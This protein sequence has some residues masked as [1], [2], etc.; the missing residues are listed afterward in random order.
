[1]T[2]QDRAKMLVYFSKRFKRL[3]FVYGA[4]GLVLWFVGFYWWA[5]PAFIVAV[6]LFLKPKLDLESVAKG[7]PMA[8]YLLDSNYLCSHLWIY[9]LTVVGGLYVPFRAS[10]ARKMFLWS[11][12]HL[13]TSP[14]TSIFELGEDIRLLSKI[15]L[16]EKEA[17]DFALYYV[18][19]LA[20][21]D[22]WY[23]LGSDEELQKF[24]LLNQTIVKYCFDEIE[25]KL[26]K[27]HAKGFEEI[28]S[29]AAEWFPGLKQE[30]VEQFLSE[31]TGNWVNL[32]LPSGKAVMERNAFET[33]VDAINKT[34]H[35][36]GRCTFQ[37][38][39][40]ELQSR[41]S[42][43]ERDAQAFIGQCDG[44]FR[45]LP[46]ADG[47]YYVSDRL[48]NQI[49]I[50]PAC[51]I[52]RVL[53]KDEIANGYSPYC[54]SY[55]EE[56]DQMEMRQA[57]ALRKEQ[58]GKAGISLGAMGATVG[59]TAH[60]WAW[61]YGRVA[62]RSNTAHGLAAEDMN[63]M[64]DKLTGHQASVVGSDNAK[65]G[66]DRLV[67]GVYY[68]SKYCRTAYHSVDQAF[69]NG[70]YCYF[71]KDGSPMKLE[72][73]KDQYV[74]AIEE[75][76]KRI[77][78][79]QVPGVTDPEEAKELVS[80]GSSTYQQSL[81]ACKF[82]TI[83]SL[84]FDAYTGVIQ[85][86]SA[87]GISFVL[88]TALGYCHTGDVE[89]A[90][91][92]A[93]VMGLKDGGKNFLSYM[94]MAQAERVPAVKSFMDSVISIN[95]GGHGKFIHTLGEN[96]CKMVS[97]PELSTTATG[98]VDGATIVDA[99]TK[100]KPR[101]HVKANNAVRG[102]VATASATF[103]VTSLWEVGCYCL[104]RMSGM[105]CFKNVVVDGAGIAGGTGGGLALAVLG[106]WLCPGVGTVIGGLL[107]GFVGGSASSYVA[108]GIMDA[109]SD[110][111]SVAIMKLVQDQ[112]VVLSAMFCLDHSEMD[113]V[114]KAIE[115]YIAD[116]G[117][118][119][120]DVYS[121]ARENMGRQYVTR[122]FKPFFVEASMKR[123][124]LL[125]KDISAESI[126][127]AVAS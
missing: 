109:I 6:T 126:V 115:S 38:V 42:M 45:N 63:T 118:F 67:D 123:P 101:I 39:N 99:A 106:T 49:A 51:G 107:G 59:K 90:I 95:F 124:M 8:Y 21:T 81:N 127:S 18:K 48:N 85:G 12:E 98:A 28:V 50:C 69:E 73:P 108:K 55:C 4:I 56:T 30:R 121:R 88:A 10:R 35:R 75:M 111:D 27:E 87:G 80:A 34:V 112:I 71:N 23:A 66:P 17:W 65:G 46:F 19:D 117:S 41:F 120:G 57:D 114:M 31:M 84:T 5:I 77:L 47:R 32:T 36:K 119:V 24:V 110:D 83:E 89:K 11:K 78:D 53:S 40:A 22:D 82:M 100:Q 70:K 122:I 2:M 58:F 125:D 62:S 20:E 64:I 79:G 9:I 15:K 104:G 52:A 96:L 3:A 93:T 105:Q 116:N 33:T 92:S 44:E 29:M 61:N 14:W 102:A 86:V 1:M 68:Q 43:K 54:S 91:R 113:E 94:I 37:D 97:A 60:S 72:V 74:E 13:E 26:A 7:M 16:S 25:E 76:R 103:A